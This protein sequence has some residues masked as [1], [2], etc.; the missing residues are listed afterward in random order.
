MTSRY[1]LPCIK[2]PIM[3]FHLKICRVNSTGSLLVT[4]LAQSGLVYLNSLY[5]NILAI[6]QSCTLKKMIDIQIINIIIVI[7]SISN[8]FVSNSIK[9]CIF[10]NQAVINSTHTSSKVTSS[11]S[12]LLMLKSSTTRPYL[13]LVER[14]RG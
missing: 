11:R 2:G 9:S 5:Y 7:I 8:N 6:I 3:Y 13:S 14:I 1:N 4:Q 12:Q 10:V